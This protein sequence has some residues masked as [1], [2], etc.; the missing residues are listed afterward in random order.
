ME[1]LSLLD[2]VIKVPSL[3]FDTIST[4]SIK[5][6]MMVNPIPDRSNSGRVVYKGSLALSIFLIPTPKSCT[7]M[8]IVF[9][10]IFAVI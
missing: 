8:T 3:A 10:T 4:L 7:L 2:I 5:F 6:S 9:S 1:V